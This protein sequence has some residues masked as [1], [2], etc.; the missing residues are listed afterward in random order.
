M[1]YDAT[2]IEVA[3]E[4]PFGLM[5][6]NSI[7]SDSSSGGIAVAIQDIFPDKRVIAKC[8]A[9]LK[10]CLSRTGARRAD[11]V[12]KVKSKYLIGK[13]KFK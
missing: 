3:S 13:L 5:S 8:Q 9:A 1:L 11:I 10:T 12:N 7:F 6:P 4:T 2:T